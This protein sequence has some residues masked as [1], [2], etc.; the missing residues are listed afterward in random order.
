[1]IVLFS[2]LPCIWVFLLLPKVVTATD[3]PVCAADCILKALD[4][5]AGSG[6]SILHP[7]KCIC[8]SAELLK[9]A[10][11]CLLQDCLSETATGSFSQ[12]YC[13]STSDTTVWDSYTGIDSGTPTS[14]T[15]S[16]TAGLPALTSSAIISYLG[17][18][19]H[20]RTVTSDSSSASSYTIGTGTFNPTTASTPLPDSVPLKVSETSV[21]YTA[22]VVTVASTAGP[23]DQS[24]SN[25]DTAGSVDNASSSSH[26]ST[27][28]PVA[29][30]VCLL[31][32]LCSA[33]LLLWRRL[34]ARSKAEPCARRYADE[35]SWHPPCEPNH[36]SDVIVLFN[37]SHG[38]G[39]INAST[40]SRLSGESSNWSKTSDLHVHSPL[41]PDTY[42][43]SILAA[44][45][46]DISSSREC[47]KYSPSW[48]SIGDPERT[49][50]R[51]AAISEYEL[52]SPQTPMDEPTLSEV[53]KG[54]CTAYSA[55]RRSGAELVAEEPAGSISQSTTSPY[56]D[57]RFNRRTSVRLPPPAAMEGTPALQLG[58]TG[59]GA[60]I[61]LGYTETLG[62]S[63]SQDSFHE[64]E[65]PRIVVNLPLSIGHRLMGMSTTSSSLY[66]EVD[67]SVADTQEL[68]APPPYAAQPIHEE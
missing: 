2:A 55:S 30:S 24:P 35:H 57:E 15:G 34:T 20:W 63:P 19:A 39:T 46:D 26:S 40:K 51:P 18:S 62:E 56:S 42:G 58:P 47:K 4:A 14:A 21:L 36:H 37:D 59:L 13:S 44:I 43:V 66:T 28:L 54:T 5:I 67:R 68:D 61:Q 11:A 38:D 9:A 16:Q 8:A 52:P 6:C 23:K 29:L 53:D 48:S 50:R 7:I 60:T 12:K 49:V 41:T 17:S 65:E 10:E 22:P 64:I 45:G 31:L 27:V 3:L 33:A 1:M 25:Q 32:V